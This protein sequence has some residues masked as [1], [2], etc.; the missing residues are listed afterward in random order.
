MISVEEH[1]C[2]MFGVRHSCIKVKPEQHSYAVMKER[3]P[4]PSASPR[5]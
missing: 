2:V 5:Q 3:W 4:A 1:L